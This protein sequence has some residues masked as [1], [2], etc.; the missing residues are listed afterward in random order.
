MQVLVLGGASRGDRALSWVPGPDSQTR[1]IVLLDP[2]TAGRQ[3]RGKLAQL[4]PHAWHAF[5]PAHHAT[6]SRGYAAAHGPAARPQALAS[7][8]GCSARLSCRSPLCAAQ[9]WSRQ[10]PSHE[11][12]PF[13]QR[14]FMPSA[15]Q[16]LRCT[17]SLCA[18]LCL[19]PMQASR[20]RRACQQGVHSQGS[21]ESTPV[22]AIGG[23]VGVH[24]AAAQRLAPPEC[25]WSSR[26]F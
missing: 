6:A 14:V 26:A 4:L 9:V 5:I 17:H 25:T 16:L 20:W 11:G 21:A 3:G 15:A 13:S 19:S 10:V 1:I 24:S 8:T 22:P 18:T 7:C 2:D 12:A 23:Q